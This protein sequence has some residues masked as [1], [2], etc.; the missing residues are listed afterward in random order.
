VNKRE[1]AI[2]NQS[3]PDAAMMPDESGAQQP[4]EKIRLRFAPQFTKLLSEIVIGE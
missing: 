2:K 4:L 3:L 1:S